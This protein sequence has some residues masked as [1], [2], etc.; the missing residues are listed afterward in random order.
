MVAART[1]IERH[2]RGAAA[3]HLAHCTRL[4]HLFTYAVPSSALIQLEM[5]RSYLRLAD[6]AGARTVLRELR[7]LLRQRPDLGA[8]P[9][10]V[11]EV[12]RQLD[13]ARLGPV[14]ASALS[15]AELRLLPYLATHLTIPEI[16]QR[17]YVSRNTVKTQAIAVYR[18]LGATSRSEAVERAHQVGLMP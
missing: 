14:G 11:E 2:D 16:G 17:L 8:V 1:A 15:A 18:K 13:A 9:T 10:Q 4:R 3:E 6:P 7:D 12:Q 5:A